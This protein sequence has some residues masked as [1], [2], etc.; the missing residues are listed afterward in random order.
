MNIKAGYRNGTDAVIIYCCTGMG[1]K[2]SMSKKTTEMNNG[3]TAGTP[4]GDKK[5]PRRGISLLPASAIHIIQLMVLLALEMVFVFLLVA[6]DVIP[7]KY[8]AALLGGLVLLDAVTVF[9]LRRRSGRWAKVAGSVIGIIVILA[10]AAGSYLMVS[11]FDTLTK[12]SSL[13]TYSTTSEIANKPFNL[14]ISGIDS[15]QDISDN[16]ARSDVNMIVTVDPKNYEVLLTS[17]P[18]DSYV[19]LHMNGEMDKLTHTGV[20]GIDETVSTVEDWL[21]VKIDYYMRV[22]F[23]MLVN[24]VDAVGGIDVY[25]DIDFYSHP[26]GW[27]YTKGMKHFTGKQAL[28]FAR[29]RKS[30]EDEDEQ[31][32]RNQ[33]KVVDALI[34]KLTN[35]STL[36]AN[37][38][39]ILEVVGANMQTDM[40]SKDMSEL[41]KL[42]IAYMPKWTIK[43]Q[44]VDGDDAEMGTWSMGPARMRFVSIPKE[45]SVKKV[46]KAINDMVNG[47]R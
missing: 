14:Y 11:T 25:N 38:S 43:K 20:Y 32:I 26:K 19:P 45:E 41:A 35:S 44:W 46:S 24:L 22:D 12:I 37:Y 2:Q 21:D 17:M 27:H 30:F 3:H 33:Q 15:R 13:S 9:L 18:R 34:E 1:L 4:A 7:G 31:R 6:V 16:A 36:I 40:S 28:W 29:E 47:E 10:M 8:F 42:Q 5:A 23:K 39:E